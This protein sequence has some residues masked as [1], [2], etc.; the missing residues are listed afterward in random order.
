MFTGIVT[1]MGRIESVEKR[2]GGARIVIAPARP[3]TYRS[4]ESVSVSG[5]CLTAVSTS[6][7]LI[8][9]LSSE[10]LRRSTL[11]ALAPGDQVI[12]SG[13]SAGATVSRATS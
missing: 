9:D 4:G 1:G 3:T 5:V 8:A 10:T 2:R 7:R 11:E 12:W 6:R 13:R